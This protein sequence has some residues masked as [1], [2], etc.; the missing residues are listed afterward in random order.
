MAVGRP[1]LV[2]AP[3]EAARSS[4]AARMRASRSAPRTARVSRGAVRTLIARSRDARGGWAPRARPRPRSTRARGRSTGSTE[5]CAMS[6]PRA[7][8]ERG[9]VRHQRRVVAGRARPSIPDEVARLRDTMR[10]RGPDG[11]GLWRRPDRGD[12]VLG[13]RRLAIVDL[14]R[15]RPAADGQ[16]GRHR[17][18]DVQRRDLQPRRAARRAR[19]ARAP[20]PLALRRRGPRPS[21]RGA[22]RRRWSTGSS[23][24]SRSRSGT[25]ATRACCW[26]ATGSGSS[27]CTGSTTARRF[28]FASEI[29]A[30][31]P[32]LPRREVDPAALEQYLSFVTVA[33]PR[34]LFRDVSKLAPATTMRVRPL[35]PAGDARPT[36]TRSAT[37][38]RCDADDVDWEAELRFR[39]ER[40][41]RRR[42]MSDVPV[43]VFLSGGVDSSTNVALFSEL[44]DGP[45][46][47]VLDRLPRRR[48]LQRARLG[49]R[50]S[51]SSSGPTTT[52]SRSTRRTCGTSC[53]S[54]SFTRT[55]RSPTPSACRC[56]SSR[57]LATRGRRHGRP[58]GRGRRRAPRRLPDV[59]HRARDDARPVAAA[60]RAARAAALARRQRRLGRSSGSAPGTRST[61]RRWARGRRR[62]QRPVVGRRRGVL[63]ARAARRHHAGAAGRGDGA[64]GPAALVRA[65]AED[66]DALRRARRPRPAHLPGPAPAPARAAADARRQAHDGQLDRGARAVPRPSSS[67][68]WR[69]RCPTI[70][71]SPAASARS[72]SSARWATCCRTTSSGARSRASAHRSR[73]GFAATLGDAPA[74]PARGLGDPRARLPRPRPHPRRSPAST[75]ADAP[76]A[77]FSSGTCSTSRCGSISW[78]AGQEQRRDV[79]APLLV[80]VGARPNLVKVAPVWHALAALRIG[81]RLLHTGQHYDHA[82]SGSFLEQLDLPE[83]DVASAIGSGTHARADRRRARGGRAGAPGRRTR[84]GARRRRRELD[85][86]ARRSP[87]RSSAC[88]SSTSRRACGP[89]TGRCPRRSTASSATACRTCCCATSRRR[90]SRRSP[91]RASTPLAR[92]LVGNTMIDTLLRL[93]EPARAQPP[94]ASASGCPRARYVLVTLHR[95]AVVDDP[96]RCTAAMD[97]SRSWPRS[98]PCSSRSIHGR[99]RG[100][101]RWTRAPV[102]AYACSSR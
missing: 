97:A 13:H 78:I 15:C 63:R 29:K 2:A 96:A 67:S 17:A 102:G 44:A 18:G 43:G 62:R 10:H 53:P 41:V 25:S 100:S 58:R 76:I 7:G 50:A 86:R 23:A 81:Q 26:P 79:S 80:V 39:L 95:P 20:L 101:A 21:L 66:A 92:V 71:R 31:L 34:T 60:A 24:C 59:R 52:R 85:A 19:G 77:R 56:T 55:S 33:P 69:W 1:A 38:S 89:A 47:D 64:A 68:S 61:P 93:S 35:G 54:S 14:T 48:G 32:L 49:A 72:P 45:G 8:A 28:A 27:R 11:E 65:I 6:P 99:E 4:R 46:A 36:G 83:P 12:V 42:M 57:R 94:N 51:P 88:R 82:L 40:S 98:C 5:C 87:R 37:A 30:L 74:G 70:R 75:R 9:R 90:A 84:R 91:P 22:R 73:S 16:R 3:G